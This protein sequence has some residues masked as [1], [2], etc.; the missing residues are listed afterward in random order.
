MPRFVPTALVAVLAA[1]LGLAAPAGAQDR[2]ALV[3]G[4]SA[5]DHAPRAV[6]AR[7]DAEAVA[8][9]LE[10]SD[11]AVTLGI[12]LDRAGMQA[13]IE[14]FAQSLAQAEKAV[15][16]VSGHAVRTGGESF[17]APADM[18]AT[19]LSAV[20][21]E[22]IPLD[23]LIRLARRAEA[24]AVVFVDA[25]QLRGFAPLPFVEPGIADI[26][27]PEGVLVVSA[28]PPGE[29]VRRIRGQDSRFARLVIDRFFEPDAPADGVAAT[30]GGT[31][32]SI[33]G[34]GPDFAIVDAPGMDDPALPREIELAFWQA[35]ERSGRAEDYE[36]YL[37][38]YPDGEF[39]PIAANRLRQI[40]EAARDPSERAEAAL[41]LSRE[42]RRQIQRALRTLGHDP[43]GIDG[44]FGPAT[45]RAIRDWQA[46]VGLRTTGYLESPQPR[47]ILAEAERLR[48]ERREAE[49]RRR[50]EAAAR[51]DA[52]WR[53]TGARGSI[54]GLKAYLSRYPQGRHAA[55][56]E[57][58]LARLADERRDAALARERRLWQRAV[59]EGSA[60]AYRRYLARFP[61]GLYATQARRR[62]AVIED[63]E[64]AT[65]LRRR[66]SRIEEKLGLRRGDRLS[67]E[68]RLQR[69]GYRPG[70][71][72]GVL[73]D[74]A[75]RAVSA[76][77]EHRG[78]PPTGFLT[79]RTL[80]VLVRETPGTAIDP[81][82]PAPVIAGLAR[83]VEGG[84]RRN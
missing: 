60:E 70:R 75:R 65:A 27:A 31:L 80:V 41:G 10:R 82:Y 84:P 67:V 25:A 81:Q 15:V 3:L 36:A 78:L 4:T 24:G 39:A 42:E 2:V 45:R 29:A 23:L 38:R 16:Y 44:V 73:N 58:R 8:E 57:A 26:A 74:R 14:A 53:E 79:K 5:Y 11:Y 59:T 72:D 83:R 48:A 64:R 62:L 22:G 40:A 68:V 7:Q 13:A 54:R 77:Q 9:M 6:S 37:A 28:A 33:G 1:A 21:L 18:R 55:E 20:L 69:L 63:G 49:V 50:A 17:V 46:S 43:R 66:H 12:D 32:W 56:A 35:A 34:V 19:T 76:F 30:V 47:R 52:Y 61:S 71:R 51:D